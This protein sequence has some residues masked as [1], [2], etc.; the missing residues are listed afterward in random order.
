MMISVYKE[1]NEERKYLGLT[2][3]PNKHHM[4]EYINREEREYQKQKKAGVDE[5]DL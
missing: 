4:R 3:T 1:V 5:R 2:I